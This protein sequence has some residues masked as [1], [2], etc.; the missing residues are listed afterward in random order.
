MG[1]RRR[2]QDRWYDPGVW[3]LEEAVELREKREEDAD[4][5]RDRL[6]QWILSL[7]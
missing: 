6:T 3:M 5:G 1:E 4:T 7:C 2:E